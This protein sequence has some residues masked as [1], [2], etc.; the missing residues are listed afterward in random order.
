MPSTA[1][2]VYAHTFYID[3][4]HGYEAN[5]KEGS[6]YTFCKPQTNSKRE[7]IAYTSLVSGLY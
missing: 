2:S 6:I 3:K 5:G 1:A 4:L 7:Q